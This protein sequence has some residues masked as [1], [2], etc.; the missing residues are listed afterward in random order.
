M[1]FISMEKF[2]AVQ[3]SAELVASQGFEPQYAESESAVL[4][5]N[6]EATSVHL[7]IEIRRDKA[8]VAGIAAE[9][10]IEPANLHIIRGRLAAGQFSI[11][12]GW[13]SAKLKRLEAFCAL[14]IKSLRILYR[15]FIDG[16]AN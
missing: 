6:D 16:A 10:G 3:G 9:S 2:N 13:L 14:L 11:G 8:N 15:P 12:N 5:L 4:P 1:A 7:A